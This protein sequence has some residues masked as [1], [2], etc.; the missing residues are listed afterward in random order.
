M[1]MKQQRQGQPLNVRPLL[2]ITI[3]KRTDYYY[4]HN[5][6]R[7]YVTA[8]KFNNFTVNWKRVSK[9]PGSRALLVSNGSPKEIEQYRISYQPCH[10]RILW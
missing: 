3:D 6:M 9:A 7:Y 1:G 10:T 4:L 8:H 2:M 5:G